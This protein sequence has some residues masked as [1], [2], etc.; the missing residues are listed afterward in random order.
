MLQALIF[1]VG[2]LQFAIGC[3][4]VAGAMQE[5]HQEELLAV[6]IGVVM[7]CGGLFPQ[8]A[9]A[10]SVKGCHAGESF[11]VAASIHLQQA[12]SFRKFIRANNAGRGQE[13]SPVANATR[14]A[15]R[16]PVI[17]EK[18]GAADLAFDD[19]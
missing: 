8:L 7:P 18:V 17:R 1:G 16:L 4:R 2:N 11:D 19:C 12:P 6:T 3:F 15:M 10:A 9:V 14:N 13:V 5:L